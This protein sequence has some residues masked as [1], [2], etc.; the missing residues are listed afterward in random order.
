MP[1]AGNVVATP[2]APTWAFN[3]TAA[4]NAA[5]GLSSDDIGK[6]GYDRDTQT[7]FRLVAVSPVTWVSAQP[8]AASP[9]VS[10]AG[11]MW[12]YGITPADNSTRTIDIAPPGDS[13]SFYAGVYAP[14]HD[15]TTRGNP[16]FY[17][18]FV[19]KSFYTNGNNQFHFDK[20]LAATTAPLDYRVASF[21]EDIR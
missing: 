9:L 12:F 21:I 5:T 16:D 10:R 11:H 15:F 8:Y 13:N 1:E 2:I 7:Y 19:V 18:C 20:Q 3:D 17:G 6:L 4:R 14:G